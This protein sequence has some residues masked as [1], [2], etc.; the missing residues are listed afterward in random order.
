MQRGPSP[1][2]NWRFFQWIWETFSPAATEHKNSQTAFDEVRRHKADLLDKAY[3]YV[4][5]PRRKYARL[6]ETFQTYHPEYAAK[7]LVEDMAADLAVVADDSTKAQ[8]VR[9]NYALARRRLARQ[10]LKYRAIEAQS[11]YA[12]ALEKDTT[13]YHRF[14]AAHDA[15]AAYRPVTLTEVAAIIRTT[16]AVGPYVGHSHGINV[17][18]IADM[19]DGGASA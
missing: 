18:D 12:E 13:A 4:E 14:R 10:G 7:I 6:G 19:L 17:R 15:L 3:L 9:K 8:V 5:F 1:T 11:G 16:S 2:I